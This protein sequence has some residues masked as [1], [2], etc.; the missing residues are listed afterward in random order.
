M[1]NFNYVELLDYVEDAFNLIFNKVYFIEKVPE[2]QKGVIY[3]KVISNVVSD[4]NYVNT[5]KIKY[6]TLINSYSKR[7]DSTRYHNK[8]G[9]IKSDIIFMYT[10]VIWAKLNK[11][12]KEDEQYGNKK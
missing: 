8:K 12:I 6:S 10:A 11:Y 4:Y 2:S 9:N 1:D 5:H 3:I 7:L